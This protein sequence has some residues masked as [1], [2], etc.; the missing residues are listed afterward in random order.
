ME[1]ILS[2]NRVSAQEI[3]NYLAEF[4][5]KIEISPCAEGEFKVCLQADDPTIIFDTC[6][7]FARIKSV[8]VNECGL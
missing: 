6:A 3:N 2:T 5:D 7:Q 1:F 4:A 8:K